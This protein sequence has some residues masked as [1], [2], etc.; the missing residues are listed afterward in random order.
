M[1]QSFLLMMMF[2][3]I[4]CS[5]AQDLK[6]IKLNAPNLTRGDVLMKAFSNRKSTREFSDK[7]LS[8]QDLSD[9]VWAANGINR[10][11]EGKKTAPS[12]QNRQDI[13]IYVCMADGNYLYNA[14]NGT[15]EFIS[16]GDVRPLKA[17]V[18]LILV[19]NTNETWGAI[20]GGIVSQ[21]ISLFCS[22]IGLATVP[23][24]QMDADALK[25]A[26]K[27]TGTQTLILNHPVGY[28]K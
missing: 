17:P 3:L 18:C 15:L 27:L 8:Q 6:S 2:M 12:S 28:F 19:S 13:K 16:E 10:P 4:S 20:D 23:R 7:M 9:L 22:G 1:K 25:K 5:S 14:S 26:L 24:A 11:N 21:N